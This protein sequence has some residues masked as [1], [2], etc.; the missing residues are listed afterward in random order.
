MSKEWSDLNL[1]LRTGNHMPGEWLWPKEDVICWRFF[2]KKGP[3]IFNGVEYWSANFP[4]MIV[5]SFKDMQK[6]IVIQAGG[7][8]GLYPK[9]Y[10]KVFNQVHTFE[11]DPKWFYCLNHNLKEQNILK[12][13]KALGSSNT[14]VRMEFNLDLRNGKQNLGANRVALGGDIEQITIDELNL[15]PDLIHL[16]I[17]GFEGEAILGSLETIRRCHP[18]IVLETNDSGKK[19][20]WTLEKIEKILFNE[21][22]KIA[23]NW[24]H[25]RAY[26]I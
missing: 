19:Y 16:D 25:D 3:H 5:D 4:N 9:L 22:Y 20:G 15:N 7:N 14:P 18:V 10:S 11:P 24:H 12:Y 26:A 23:K 1:S 17:E 8:A 2:T 21:G 13:N 6:N